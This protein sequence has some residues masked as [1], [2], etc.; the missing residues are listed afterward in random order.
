MKNSE[1]PRLKVAQNPKRFSSASTRARNSWP[2]GTPPRPPRNPG[3]P[4]Y[5][6]ASNPSSQSAAFILKTKNGRCTPSLHH[7]QILRKRPL[8]ID[9][10]FLAPESRP[11]RHLYNFRRTVLVRAFRPDCV[12]F[13]EHH[14]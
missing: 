5:S 13:V 14:P 12:P 2:S 4:T 9:P 6:G 1:I 8:S 3:P 7:Q 10:L 11:F